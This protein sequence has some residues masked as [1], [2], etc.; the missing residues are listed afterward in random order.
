MTILGWIFTF[1]FWWDL[2][3]YSTIFQNVDIIY[4]YLL[5]PTTL[6]SISSEINTPSLISIWWNEW[7]ICCLNQFELVLC[8]FLTNIVHVLGRIPKLSRYKSTTLTPCINRCWREQSQLSFHPRASG[9]WTHMPCQEK[10]SLCLDST[11]ISDY[12]SFTSCPIFKAIIYHNDNCNVVII[13]TEIRLLW[14]S[15]YRIIHYFWHRKR[16]Q[17]NVQ[18]NVTSFGKVHL[19]TSKS[20]WQLEIKMHISIHDWKILQFLYAIT[21]VTES[22]SH[23]KGSVGISKTRSSERNWCTV[24]RLHIIIKAA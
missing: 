23:W 17:H 5:W 21:R 2:R 7:K 18:N 16:L 4:I 20:D 15:Y 9:K 6:D 14:A 3:Y 24:C 13:K 12:L 10:P 19:C 1:L 22:Q 8:Y 11:S